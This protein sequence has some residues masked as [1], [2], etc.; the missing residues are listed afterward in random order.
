M[1]Y[2][3]VTLFIVLLSWFMQILAYLV[4][5]WWT[6]ILFKFMFSYLFKSFFKM[7]DFHTK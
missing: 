7:T 1:V 3:I 4:L 6:A 5:A 2:P